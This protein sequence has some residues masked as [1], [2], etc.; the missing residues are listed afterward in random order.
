MHHWEH[1]RRQGC[2]E[3]I[4]RDYARNSLLNV[5]TRDTEKLLDKTEIV[6]RSDVLDSA[7][8]YAMQLYD[9]QYGKYELYDPLAM[10]AH[11]TMRGEW[12]EDAMSR[13]PSV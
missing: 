9:R 7:A 4:P 2:L 12:K 10:A 6:D 11:E 1:K 3:P 8:R 5:V 13:A